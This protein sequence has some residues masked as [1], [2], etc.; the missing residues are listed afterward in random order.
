MIALLACALLACKRKESQG[1]SGSGSF[2]ERAAKLKPD[3]RKRLAQ[4]AALAP[5]VRAEAAV[6]SDRP[7]AVKPSRQ[8]VAITGEQAL[9]DPNRSKSSN[10]VNFDNTLLSL[11][12]HGTEGEPS[13]ENDVKYLEQC[14]ALRIVAVIRQKSLERPKIKMKSESYDSG[15]LKVDVLVY[16]LETANLLGAYDVY[17]TNDAELKMPG[18]DQSEEDWMGMAMSNL[19]GNVETKVEEKLGIRL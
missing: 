1:G 17:V 4:V 10:E 15:K 13:S 7:V 16:E 5:K 14:V 8:T 9:T 11:C 3:A 6:T 19:K 18:K 12:K 2:S